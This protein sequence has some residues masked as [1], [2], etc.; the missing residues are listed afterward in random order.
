[1]NKYLALLFVTLSEATIG[2]FVKLSDVGVHVFSLNFY[3]VFF[4]LMF[5]LITLPFFDKKFFKLPK[6]DIKDA[7]IIGFLIALQISMFNIAMRLAPIAN[8]VIFWSIAP[9]FVF[10][11]SSIFLKEKVKKQHIF[12]FLIAILGIVIAKPFSGGNATGNLIALIDGAVYAALVTYMRH[13]NKTGSVGTVFWY[14]LVASIILLPAIFIF[15]TGNLGQMLSYPALGVNLPV[16]LWVVCLGVVSTGVAYL[17]ISIALKQINA[18]IY[19]LVDII[20]S[21]IVAGFFGYWLFNE[22]PSENMFYGGALLLISGFWLSNY[23]SEGKKSWIVNLIAKLR[24]KGEEEPVSNP[25][26]ENK[27]VK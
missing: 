6:K 23:M 24:G 7:L 17:F 20:V 10:I 13:E 12:I 16:I 18:N 9:F 14:M 8:V 5:L 25:M 22:L 21:P 3:R 19:S 1:M 15:G 26:L 4:A 2:V 27:T 11:F